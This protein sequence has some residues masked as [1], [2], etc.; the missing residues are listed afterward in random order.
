MKL[1]V[2]YG[3]DGLNKV[4]LI[5]GNLRMVLRSG[6]HQNECDAFIHDLRAVLGCNVEFV[7]IVENEG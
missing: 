7:Q 3:L 6:L 1:K 5:N 4:I 2:E